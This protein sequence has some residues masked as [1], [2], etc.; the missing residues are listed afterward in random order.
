MIC[1]INLQLSV[2]RF[3]IVPCK[4]PA[5]YDI[6]IIILSTIVQTLMA[7]SHRF[8]TQIFKFHCHRFIN[9]IL[10]VYERYPSSCLTIQHS[11]S[12]SNKLA[13]SVCRVFD[14]LWWAGL[15]AHSFEWRHQITWHLP[16]CPVFSSRDWSHEP[17]QTK[18]LHLI[19]LE[20]VPA[21]IKWYIFHFWIILL[22]QAVSAHNLPFWM[23]ILR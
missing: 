23:R 10:A 4:L 8:S 20:Q 5:T 7:T 3:S 1:L 18:L 13:W 6:I 19:W 14:L 12:L 17:N 9:M 22:P 2:L 15:S 11:P 16:H 21:W